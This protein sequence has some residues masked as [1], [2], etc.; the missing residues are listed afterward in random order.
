MRVLFMKLFFSFV[1]LVA[2]FLSFLASAAPS[3]HTLFTIHGSNTVGASLAPRLV[4]KYLETLGVKNIHIKKLSVDNEKVIKGYLLE[5][6][7]SV[8]VL[9]SAHGS[10]TGFK[11]LMSNSADIW[12]SS[13]AVKN[14]EVLSAR[15]ISDL[16]QSDSEHVLAIDGLAIIVHPQNPVSALSKHQLAKI[17]SGEI[18]NWSQVGGANQAIKLFARDE[19]SGTWDSF[20]NMVLAKT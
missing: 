6:G 12:A 8:Q 17:Y 19:N 1:F 7:K 14:K 9:I 2:S 16:S 15:H 13:R 18:N 4:V 10:S 20:K 11:G 3:T 5:Q